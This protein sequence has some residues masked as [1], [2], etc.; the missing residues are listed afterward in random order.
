MM[1]NKLIRKYKTCRH[2]KQESF[3]KYNVGTL[4]NAIYT[5]KLLFIHIPKTAG[6][7]VLKAIYGDVNLSGHRNYYFNTVALNIS[8]KNIFFSFAFIRNPFDRLYSSYLFLKKGG[9]NIHDENAYIKHLSKFNDFEDFILNGLNKNIIYEIPHFIPQCEYI[10]DNNNKI[11]VDYLGRF[12]NLNHDIK[13][14]SKKINKD[15]NLEHHNF[16]L[17]KDYRTAYNPNMIEIV[18]KIYSNDLT[19]FNYKFE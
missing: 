2:A 8:K 15:I 13:I 16:N 3:K 17:V 19:V 14:L 12:E 10:C 18:S 11:L 6:I 9:I 5:T 4:L 7:S 1:L